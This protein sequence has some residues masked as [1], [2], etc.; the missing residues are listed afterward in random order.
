[1]QKKNSIRKEFYLDVSRYTFDYLF[2]IGKKSMVVHLNN[3]LERKV[4]STLMKNCFLG[5]SIK[6]TNYVLLRLCSDGIKASYISEKASVSMDEFIC[7]LFDYAKMEDKKIEHM[8]QSKVFTNII[9]KG[10]I[11]LGVQN[12]NFLYFS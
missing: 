11:S 4:M 3:K 1:M 6:K 5:F 8:T 7:I 10:F 2:D 12:S 9:S